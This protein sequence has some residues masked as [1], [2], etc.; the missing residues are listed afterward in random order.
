MCCFCVRVC[1]RAS[2]WECGVRG[3]F[4]LSLW[5]QSWQ[6]QPCNGNTHT[7]THTKS[8]H[9]IILRQTCKR[10]HMNNAYSCNYASKTTCSHYS[11]CHYITQSMVGVHSVLSPKW[12][13]IPHLGL[14]SK[15]M[16]YVGHRV[17]VETHPRIGSLLR[18]L[19]FFLEHPS[20]KGGMWCI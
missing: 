1:V 14:W 2:F 15:V 13:P 5:G 8:L 20:G 12:H 6:S 4:S 11:V 18:G 16:Q 3:S 7:H 17:P 19:S 10:K 9:W